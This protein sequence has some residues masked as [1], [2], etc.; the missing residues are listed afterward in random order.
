[1]DCTTTRATYLMPLLNG[2]GH[3][4]FSI[5]LNRQYIFMNLIFFKLPQTA[6]IRTRLSLILIV[7][8]FIIQTGV[9]V[10]NYQMTKSTMKAGLVELKNKVIKQLTIGLKEPLWNYQK[11][12]FDDIIDS[13]ML[14]NQIYAILIKIIKA[15]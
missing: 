6:G 3:M 10:I 4:E 12:M 14:E 9:T 5:H 2:Y 13:Q 11:D 7:T 8:I 15:V 1:M